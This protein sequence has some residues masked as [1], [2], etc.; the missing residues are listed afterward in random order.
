MPVLNK[1]SII[2]TLSLLLAIPLN[3]AFA[4][5]YDHEMQ[6]DNMTF[7][8]TVN[9]P[10]LDIKIRAKTT[11][12]VAVGFNPSNRMQDANIII[13]YVTKDE[14]V[15]SDDFGFRE[16]GHRKDKNNNIT[17]QTGSEIAGVTTLEFT[18]PL[19]S[20]DPEDSV[21]QPDADTKI[22]FAYGAGRDNLRS[23]HK[24]RATKTIN[25]ANGTYSG[26]LDHSA[27]THG[28]A[29]QH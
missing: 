15:I 5:E 2:L 12:W 24:Y 22:I 20:G 29:D 10:N 28:G 17:N 25:L 23:R 26:D 27:H 7:A 4:R 19:N 11:G 21:I 9:G 3:N 18:I 6:D 1:I 16:T 13:G 8:W 14:V